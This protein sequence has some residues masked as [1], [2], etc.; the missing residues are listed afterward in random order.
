MAPKLSSNFKFILKFIL[1][2]LLIHPQR[3]ITSIITKKVSRNSTYIQKILSILDIPLPIWHRPFHYF[4]APF[5][6][7]SI[8]QKLHFIKTPFE[9]SFFMTKGHLP[10]FNFPWSFVRCTK[11]SPCSSNGKAKAS[12][13]T[14]LAKWPNSR[15]EHHLWQFC[16]AYSTDVIMNPP[17]SVL[18]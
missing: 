9:L 6:K 16:I 17:G 7:S 14:E 11:H 13:S 15:G 18:W 12:G 1:S 8:S 10:L 3:L 5:H 2:F 4:R